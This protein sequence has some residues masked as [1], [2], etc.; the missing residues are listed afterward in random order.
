MTRPTTT[1][2]GRVRARIFALILEED[3][4]T[5]TEYAFMLAVLSLGVIGAIGLLGAKNRDIWTTVANALIG[6]N[7]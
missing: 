5:T 4:P 3:G 6:K 2:L 7:P 1:I